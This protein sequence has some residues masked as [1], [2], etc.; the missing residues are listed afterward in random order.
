MYANHLIVLKIASL[1]YFFIFLFL[2]FSSLIYLVYNAENSGISSSKDVKF[3]G[4]GFTLQ[5][6]QNSSQLRRMSF[7]A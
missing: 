6:T 7:Q 1:I 2:F 3:V 5:S 4:I